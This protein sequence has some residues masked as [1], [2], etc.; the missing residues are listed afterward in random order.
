MRALGSERLFPSCTRKWL[1][2]KSHRS[3]I[4][5]PEE[6][7]KGKSVWVLQSTYKSSHLRTESWP[8]SGEGVMERELLLEMKQTDSIGETEE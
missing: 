8:L 6:I 7:A 5:Q 1:T 3:F 2:H 4:L